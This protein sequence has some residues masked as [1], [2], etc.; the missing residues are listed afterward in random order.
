MNREFFSGPQRAQIAFRIASLGLLLFAGPVRAADQ[1]F[2]VVVA[3]DSTPVMA[4]EKSIGDVTKGARLTVSQTNGD[5]YLIDVPNANPPQQGWIHK[6]DVQ[7]AAAIAASAPPTEIQE[8]LKERDALDHETNQLRDAGKYAEAIVAATKMLAIERSVLGN[9]HPNTLGSLDELASFNEELQ[10]FDAARKFRQ[11]ILDIKT[12]QLGRD[13]WQ[14]ADARFALQQTAL[15][16]KRTPDQRSQLHDAWRYSANVSKLCG[17]GRFAEALEPAQRSLDI[18]RKILGPDHPACAVS[19][20]WLANICQE[21]GDCAKAESL[22]QEALRIVKQ[23]QGERHP[24]YTSCL[25]DL[26]TL[27]QHEGKYAKAEPLRLQAMSI[28]KEILGENN[29]DYAIGLSSLATLYSQMG[30]YAKSEPLCKQA[31]Q[32][33]KELVGESDPSY[34]LTLNNLALL[35]RELGDYAKAMSVCKQVVEIRKRVLG[36]RHPEYASSLENLA[37][38]YASTGDFAKAE[39]LYRQSLEIIRQSVGEKHPKYASA[40]NN[41]AGFFDRLGDYAQ[42]ETRYR[43]ALDVEKQTLGEETPDYA[44]Y[45][46][47]LAG[48]YGRHGDIAKAEVLY[49]QAIQINQRLLG[50]KHPDYASSLDSLGLLYQRAGEYAKAE[51]L[52]RRALEIRKDALGQNR[53]DYAMSLNNL[54]TLYE[55]TGKFDHA[56]R[57]FQQA[58]EIQK[59]TLGEQHTSYAVSLNNLATIYRKTGNYAKAEPLFKQAIEIQRQSLG[60][61]HPAYADCLHTLA[62]LYIDMDDFAKAEPLAYQSLRISRQRLDLASTAQSERQ[63]LLAAEAV[64]ARLHNYVNIAQRPGAPVEKVYSEVLAWKGA[65]TA[66]QQAMR[67]LGQGQN[68]SPAAALYQQLAETGRRLET[69]SRAT[70]TAGQAASHRRRVEQL[71]DELEN[72]EQKLATVSSDFHQE[73]DQRNRGPDDIRRALP[74]GTA[75]I[76]FL[77]FETSKARITPSAYEIESAL[78]AFIVRSD[79]PVESVYLGPVDPIAADITAWRKNFGMSR[80]SDAT[81]PGADL[82]RLVWDKLQSHLGDAKIVLISPDGVTAQFPW[83]AL[84]GDK[85]NTYL[86]DDVAI[87]IVPVPRLLPDILARRAAPMDQQSSGAPSLLLVGDVDFGA[88]PGVRAPIPRTAQNLVAA[89]GGQPLQWH[90]LPGT[91]DE[92]AAI[93]STFEKQFGHASPEELTGARATKSAVCAAAGRCQYLHISTH[94]FFA[95]AD[96]KSA[97]SSDAPPDT[98]D[99]GQTISRQDLSSYHPD[100]L[101]GLVLAGAN[102]PIADGQEVGILTALEVSELDLGRVELATLSACETGLGKSAGGEGLLGLQR[103]FQTA[104]AKTVVASLWQVPDKATQLL[105]S[106]FYDNLWHKHMSKLEALRAA[107]R[108]LLREGSKQPEVV[109]GLELSSEPEETNSGP[110]RLSPRYWAAFELSGDWR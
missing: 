85:P 36:E 9:G 103:A 75:L 1:P 67:R 64:R 102:R 28:D 18:H 29:F 57:L 25:D 59:Q 87:A 108:W 72:L 38:I 58:L 98:P 89:R 2:D 12:Q 46:G 21:T 42:A 37:F 76:D 61:N 109:R 26:A 77:E 68:G 55:D 30:E 10:N 73:L 95:P 88:D 11:E 65:V 13:H 24:N 50:E 40:L 7:A 43:Q 56:E 51:P 49:R 81:S 100:L 105:M 60:E 84:P 23:S 5:W 20:C 82:R 45:L 16:E 27:Y 4:G 32:I 99:L 22:L 17:A 6:A 70:P 15:L 106:R 66:R 35:Y 94:G 53:P 31:L 63:Q 69:E 52:L 14:V 41:L 101:S 110:S 71:S 62:L 86:I 93:K 3:A 83:L 54:G 79:K 33:K 107:Q 47:N 39:P 74:N 44:T 19:C 34:L 80:S 78:V 104:G 8:R 48:L 90:S 96:L 92:V 97:F 91:R